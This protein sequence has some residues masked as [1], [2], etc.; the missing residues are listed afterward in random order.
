VQ[1]DVT[2]CGGYTEWLRIAALAAAYGL[3]VSGH[4]APSLHA[5]V[6]MAVA[7]L[8]HLEWFEDHVRIEGRFLDGFPAPVA[9][10]IAPAEES[11]HGLTLREADLTD[12]RVA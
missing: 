9:G 1:V 8:R 12:Y 4:C 7:N 5:P 10:S 11:G 2:R 3:E 6:S